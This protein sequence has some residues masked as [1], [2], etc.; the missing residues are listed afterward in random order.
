MS[1]KL[2]M[3]WTKIGDLFVLPMPSEDKAQVWTSRDLLHWTKVVLPVTAGEVLA[4]KA[5]TTG[6]PGLVAYGE[7]YLKSD[8]SFLKA[9]W[10]STD[11][12]SWKRDPSTGLTPGQL[13][14]LRATGEGSVSY[15]T[16]A[17]DVT[18]F[19][20]TPFESDGQPALIVSQGGATA[21]TDQMDKVTPVEMWQAIGANGWHKVR[22]LPKSSN[23][24]HVKN[25]VQGP[26]GYFLFGCGADCTQSLGWS[27]ADGIAWRSVISPDIDGL[28]AIL[29]VD[30]GFIGLGERV[31]GLGCAVGDSEIFGVTWTSPDGRQWTKMKE[32]AQFNRAA[33][34]IAIVQGGTVYG[35]G[36]RWPT[37]AAGP[38][39]TVWTAP[40]PADSVATIPAPAPTG[41]PPHGGCGE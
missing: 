12:S 20:G 32:E 30:S 4:V 33:I 10:T 8:D 37:A 23:G 2:N 26:R 6:G 22:V 34:H 19:P 27:S 5:V 35:L 18:Q 31:T 39:S 17:V 9:T 14:L 13:W 40:L 3:T 25:A 29:A 21:F 36:V 24:G 28:N 16:G 15:L 41:T 38:V 1:A 11:G 7:G